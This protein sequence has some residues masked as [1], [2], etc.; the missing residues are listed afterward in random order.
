MIDLADKFTVILSAVAI[1]VS[2]LALW[3]TRSQSKA[4]HYANYIATREEKHARQ[5]NRLTEQ[6]LSLTKTTIAQANEIHDPRLYLHFPKNPELEEYI[7]PANGDFYTPEEEEKRKL[8]LIH[9]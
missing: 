7:S 5:A 8:S 3:Y 2:L 1:V 9:I 6:A 4:A